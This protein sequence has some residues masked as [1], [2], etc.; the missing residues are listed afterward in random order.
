MYVFSNLALKKNRW[1]L[2]VLVFH[3]TL[4]DF[5]QVKILWSSHVLTPHQRKKTEIM[6]EPISSTTTHDHFLME[7][8]LAL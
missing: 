7:M 1:W 3:S 8:S 5:I 4:I 6:E 2:K